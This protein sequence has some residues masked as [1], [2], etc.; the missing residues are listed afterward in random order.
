MVLTPAPAAGSELKVGQAGL[1][2]ND[3]ALIQIEVK[4]L[5]EVCLAI[6]GVDFRER[7][8]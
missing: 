3:V 7:A 6:V 4:H 5:L 8:G 1:E 2:A